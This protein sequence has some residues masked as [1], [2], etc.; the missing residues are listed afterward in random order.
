M[1][2]ASTNKAPANKQVNSSGKVI[3]SKE[4]SKIGSKEESKISSKEESKKAPK[5][6]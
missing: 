3:N 5:P 1:K 6:K 2:K 4:E